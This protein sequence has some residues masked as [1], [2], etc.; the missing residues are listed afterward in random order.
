MGVADSKSKGLKNN[1]FEKVGS[2]GVAI[3]PK[4]SLVY[5]KVMTSLESKRGVSPGNRRRAYSVDST[6]DW[7]FFEDFEPATPTVNTRSNDDFE[8][9]E[10]IKRALSLPPPATAPPMYILESS[11]ETQQLWHSTAGQRP[12]QP[13]QEREYFEKLWRRNFEISSVTYKDNVIPVEK[14]TTVPSSSAAS[15]VMSHM[16]LHSTVDLSKPDVTLKIQ[17]RDDEVPVKEFDGEILFRGKGPFSNSVSK[18]FMDDDVNAMT[19]QVSDVI[20]ILMSCAGFTPRS[21]SFRLKSYNSKTFISFDFILLASI[22]FIFIE[23]TN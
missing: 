16:D 19:L 23:A 17:V 2:S 10:P 7:G 14:V 6:D 5:Q 3:S 15:S 9:S 1:F 20:N 21:T 12:K 11:L 18:S 22:I 4:M 13:Q 8:S